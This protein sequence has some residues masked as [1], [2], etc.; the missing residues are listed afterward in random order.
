MGCGKEQP[1]VV[2]RRRYLGQ[3]PVADRVVLYTAETLGT[4]F[5]ALD[6]ACS[7]WLSILQVA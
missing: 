5:I 2:W 1:W 6:V 7:K 3:V 4:R